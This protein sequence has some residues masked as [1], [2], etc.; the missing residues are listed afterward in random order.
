MKLTTD[1]IAFR[2]GAVD[3]PV[4][5]APAPENPLGPGTFERGAVPG[6]P[7][8]VRREHGLAPLP[9]VARHVVNAQLIW[10]LPRDGLG[11]I[12]M[13][14]VVPGDGIDIVTT[15][16][17]VAVPPMGAALCGVFPLGLR[18]EPEGAACRQLCQD[19]RADRVRIQA[20][21]EP[22][23]AGNLVPGDVFD[24]QVRSAIDGRITV[25]TDDV[26][27][28]GLGDRDGPNKEVRHLHRLELRTVAERARAATRTFDPDDLEGMVGAIGVPAVSE[29]LATEPSG[30]ERC[31]AV[32]TGS[33]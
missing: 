2:H 33:I 30:V 1:L 6:N 18:R 11:V 16:E 20:V 27:P 19:R 23:R 12:A 13:L 3:G 5:E 10:G 24:G 22:A 31:L 28:Q 26:R 8:A 14:T 29:T 9:D 7:R 32:A 21:Q 17:A 25:G 15:A 4:V